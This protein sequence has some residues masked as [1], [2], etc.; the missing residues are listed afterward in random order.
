MATYF[1]NE[2]AF[3]LPDIGFVDRTVTYFEAA[4]P[5]GGGL[6][7]LVE[8]TPLEEG[9]SLEAMVDKHVSETQKRLVGYA[10]LGKG[11]GTIE[12]SPT[13]EVAA[14]WRHESGMVY[15]RHVHVVHRGSWL[16]FAG[17]SPLEDRP[18]CDAYMDHVVQ[19]IRLRD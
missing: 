12:G 4:S 6:V 10:L 15:S 8:R 19:S 14:K 13:I 5:K 7:L 9:A 3:D 17:E 1:M 18:H 16:I 2:A 11:A